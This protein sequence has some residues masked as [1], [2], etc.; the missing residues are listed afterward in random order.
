M[1]EALFYAF[2]V[3]IGFGIFYDILRLFRLTVGLDLFFDLLF[4]VSC[5]FVTFSYLLIFNNGEIRWI[6]LVTILVGFLVYILS[7]GKLFL[8]VQKT[9]AKKVKIRL[10]K[11]KK[12]LQLPYLLYYNI[13]V[14]FKKPN[15]KKYEGDEF[16]KS[17]QES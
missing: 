12:V 7:F 6:Y 15:H 4:W 16:G 1:G 11:I 13:K 10:K 8:P 17:E 3:G 14:K 2:F 5:S 9:I